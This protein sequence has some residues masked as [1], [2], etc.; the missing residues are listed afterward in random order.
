MHSLYQKGWNR[1]GLLPDK[2]EKKKTWYVMKAYYES[3]K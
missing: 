2:G 3:I 1:K